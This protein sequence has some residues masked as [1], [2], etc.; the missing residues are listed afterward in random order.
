MVSG[1][2]TLAVDPSGAVGCE[3]GKPTFLILRV[4]SRVQCLFYLKGT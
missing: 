2:K 4:L 1:T 3:V